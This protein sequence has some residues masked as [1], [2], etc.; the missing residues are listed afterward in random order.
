MNKEYKE[1]IMDAA[2]ACYSGYVRGV[3]GHSI[4]TGDKLPDWRYLKD[5][6]KMAW[7]SAVESVLAHRFVYLAEELELRDK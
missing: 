1:H 5:E 2:E 4:V 7:I 3:R 6:V